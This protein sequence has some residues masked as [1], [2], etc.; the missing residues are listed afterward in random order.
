MNP[1]EARISKNAKTILIYRVLVVFCRFFLFFWL[2]KTNKKPLE[3]IKTIVIYSVLVFFFGF[4]GFWASEF[5]G[6]A[7]Q[8]QRSG[9]ISGQVR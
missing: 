3:S 9:G 1:A 6:L 7:T 8:P 4:F 5:D 2:R